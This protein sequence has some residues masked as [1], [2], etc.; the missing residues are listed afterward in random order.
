M[1][2]YSAIRKKREVRVSLSTNYPGD[3]EIKNPPPMQ[4]T[5]V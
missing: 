1:E 4:E 2:N 3:S 5:Q